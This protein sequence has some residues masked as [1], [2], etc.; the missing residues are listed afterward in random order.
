MKLIKINERIIKF[1]VNQDD[2]N[3]DEYYN[4]LIFLESKNI[5]TFGDTNYRVFENFFVDN[6]YNPEKLDLCV[7]DD[8]S[9]GLEMPK[10]WYLNKG[11]HSL[12]ISMYYN[13]LNWHGIVENKNLETFNKKIFNE[14]GR[15]ACVEVYLEN[16]LKSFLDLNNIKYFGTPRT[17]TECVRY[18]EGWNIEKYPRLKGYVIFSKFIELWSKTNFPNLDLSE[19]YLGKEKSNEINKLGGVTNVRKAVRYFWQNYL[20]KKHKIISD[21]DV[22]IDILDERFYKIRQPKIILLSEDLFS[23]ENSNYEI[24]EN[25]TKKLLK[26]KIYISKSKNDF[27][28]K[29]AEIAKEIY[30]DSLIVIIENDISFS[31][32]FSL[33]NPIKQSINTD[34]IIATKILRNILENSLNTSHE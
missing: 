25:L 8:K 32:N 22:E 7:N 31:K 21:E 29:N 30:P 6:G 11:K 2:C 33:I 23:S 20:L 24:F 26:D 18:L 19:W 16:E 9:I 27:P 13:Y 28:A 15:M 3:L 34:V 10:T 5:I 12:S 1:I 4:N 17:L 14:Y